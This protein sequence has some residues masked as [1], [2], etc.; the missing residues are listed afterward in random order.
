MKTQFAV[1]AVI[2]GCAIFASSFAL[3][4]PEVLV[5]D[6]IKFADGP[7]T[8]TGGAF[9]LT[10]WNSTGTMSKG[11]FASFCIEK[12][13][14]M[15]FGG[16]GYAVGPVFKVDSIST[17]AQKGGVGGS[18]TTLLKPYPHDPL[19]IE[20]AYL[21]TNYIETPSALDAVAG[22]SSANAEDKGTAMQK[23]IWKIEEEITTTS[24]TLADALI[25]FAAGS[26]WTDTG[27]VKVLNLSWFSGG[28]TDYP[29]GTFAQDQLYLQPIPEPETYAMMLAG[30]GLIGAIARR[31]KQKLNA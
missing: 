5:G 23:A 4:A 13:E 28:G 3:A 24:N 31:R 22:W 30:L 25:T 29:K 11:S 15:N 14:H 10:V 6:H 8:G 20:T 12:N 27:R 26:G 16:P 19:N 18:T 21:Y 9:E 17:D 7:G 1:K 2:A